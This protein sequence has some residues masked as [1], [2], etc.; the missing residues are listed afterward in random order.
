MIQVVALDPGYGNTKICLN[1][2]DGQGSKS[3][4]IQSAVARSRTFGMAGIGMRLAQHATEVRFGG[5]DLF[6]GPGAWN[7]N[8]PENNLDFSALTSLGR[9]AL[10]YAALAEVLEPGDYEIG[11][12]VIG[13]PVPLLQDETQAAAVM[14]ALKAYKGDHLFEVGKREYRLSILRVKVLPQPVG[15]YADWLINDDLHARKGNTQAEIGVLDIGQNTLD[16][17]AMQGGKVTPRFVGG[18]KVGGRRLLDLMDGSVAGRDPVEWDAELRSGRLKP[19]P[20]HLQSW[21][22]EIMGA[23]ERVWPNL[24]RFTAVI[25]GGGGSLLLGDLLR[26]A[27]AAHGA[28]VFTPADPVLTNAI[29]LWKYAAMLQR[30][31]GGGDASA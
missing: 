29:G 31:E 26:A 24:R 25:P 12:L 2:P 10:F 6:V 3:V 27:L 16:L 20:I 5:H 14:S 7:W 8:T 4:L 13:L 11:H 28:A 22:G 17:Y 19:A 15:A 21:L 30:K 23:V 9:Q 1:D 18:G